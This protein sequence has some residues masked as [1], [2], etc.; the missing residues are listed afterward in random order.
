L[1]FLLLPH[2]ACAH[3]GYLLLMLRDAATGGHNRSAVLAQ[4]RRMRGAIL[5][6]RGVAI[7]PCSLHLCCGFKR[8]CLS[9]CPPGKSV[10]DFKN[11]LSSP[12]LKNI[13]IFRSRKSVYKRPRPAPPEGRWPS[14]RTLERDAVDAKAAHDE[15]R[16]RGRQNRVVLTPRCW[17]QVRGASSAGDGGKKARSPGRARYKP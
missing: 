10:R 9:G 5:I 4:S 6:L 16:C 14:S 1:L 3:A 7:R 2:I 12:F 15:R 11:R 8:M 13:L 17:C